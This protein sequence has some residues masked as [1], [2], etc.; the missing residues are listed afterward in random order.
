MFAP[1]FFGGTRGQTPKTYVFAPIVSCFLSYKKCNESWKSNNHALFDYYLLF[2]RLLSLSIFNLSSF[3][4]Q[5]ERQPLWD[6]VRSLDL[7]QHIYWDSVISLSLKT[8]QYKKTN[9]HKKPDHFLNLGGKLIF[10][11]FFPEEKNREIDL[12]PF[13][14][15]K[16]YS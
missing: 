2:I 16:N 5:K 1:F 12:W 3:I 11:I 10:F 6:S 14:K 13:L 4:R 9:N 7:P 8:L 15:N